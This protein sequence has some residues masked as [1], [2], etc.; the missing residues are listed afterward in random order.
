MNSCCLNY[1]IIPNENSK[2]KI[3]ELES[4]DCGK[5]GCHCGYIQYESLAT[6]MP[7][8]TNNYTKDNDHILLEAK[9]RR[10]IIEISRLF[11]AATKVED[12]FY[13][14]AHY[15]VIKVIGN[16]TSYLS[17]PDVVPE[18]LELYTAD[19]Y[20]INPNTY[21]YKDGHIITNPCTS[22]SSTCGCSNV[23]GQY[24]ARSKLIGWNGCFQVKAKFGKECADY[25][26]QM[27]VRDY[28]IEHN[29]FSD[30][31]EVRFNGLTPRPFRE[32][33]SWT[34]LVQ[35]YLEGKRVNNYFGFA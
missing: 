32:P 25:A 20:L 2:P 10:Q 30:E 24:N 27:A 31:K 13:S 21:I 28:L 29:T 8:L 26:V 9:L 23:C 12:G 6:D 17:I 3:L 22:H 11:D 33:H 4:S 7:R 1:Y 19:G 35:K 15:K 5:C 18:S 34:T 16:G 14:K